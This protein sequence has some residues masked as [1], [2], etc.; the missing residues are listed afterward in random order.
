MGTSMS[1]KSQSGSNPLV[2][3]WAEESDSVTISSGDGSGEEHEFSNDDVQQQIPGPPP[4]HQGSNRFKE[5]RQAFGN[6]AKKGGNRDDLKSS[7]KNML[8]S[9][10][11]KVR[12]EPKGLQVV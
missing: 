10:Q 11:V 1:G 2:P 6:Y 9:P 12:G 3:P 7:L 5:A 4:V 8:L